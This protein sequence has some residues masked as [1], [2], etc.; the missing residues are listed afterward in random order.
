MFASLSSINQKPHL[1]EMGQILVA[2]N[3]TLNVEVFF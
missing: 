1:N 2:S 3:G